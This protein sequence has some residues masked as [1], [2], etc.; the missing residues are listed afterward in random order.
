MSAVWQSKKWK[1]LCYFFILKYCA[2][3]KFDLWALLYSAGLGKCNELYDDSTYQMVKIN[4]GN[5]QYQRPSG[6]IYQ[7]RLRTSLLL[8]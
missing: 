2:L 3:R 7:Q 5:T 8:G 4:Q 1:N 6:G